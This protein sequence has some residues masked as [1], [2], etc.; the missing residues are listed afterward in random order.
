MPGYVFVC[1][2]D[3]KTVASDA[4]SSEGFDEALMRVNEEYASKRKSGRLAKPE[5]VVCGYEE[6]VAKL[7]RSDARYQMASPAQFK[8]LPL[9]QTVWES[10]AE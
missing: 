2:T 10:L 7:M 8:P 4:V 1:V 6:L 3:V 9:Y 5:M